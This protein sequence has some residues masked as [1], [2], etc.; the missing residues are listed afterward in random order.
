MKSSTAI[1][2]G[3]VDLN[4]LKPFGRLSLRET[5]AKIVTCRANQLSR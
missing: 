3:R 2:Q 5:Y 4:F 1:N